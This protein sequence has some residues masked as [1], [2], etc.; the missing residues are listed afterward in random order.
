MYIPGR[1]GEEGQGSDLTHQLG[2]VQYSLQDSKERE[3]LWYS[4]ECVCAS[5]CVGVGW[6][7]GPCSN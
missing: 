6:G 1:K 3:A 2:N 4:R 7:H 5:V